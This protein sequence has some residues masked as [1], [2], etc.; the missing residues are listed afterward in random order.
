M[1]N[2]SLIFNPMHRSIVPQTC[3]LKIREQTI[4]IELGRGLRVR[5]A[6]FSFPAGCIVLGLSFPA[7]HCSYAPLANS[8]SNM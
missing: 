5:S 7:H 6:R 1:Q 3:F 8:A 2:M 4:I